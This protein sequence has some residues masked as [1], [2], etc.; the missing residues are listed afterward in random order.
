MTIAELIERLEAALAEL[1][2]SDRGQ[3]IG[4]GRF[5]IKATRDRGPTGCEGFDVPGT[6]PVGPS[7]YEGRD[8]FVW[9][10]DVSRFNSAKRDINRLFPQSAWHST[11]PPRASERENEE[12]SSIAILKPKQAQE[13]A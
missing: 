8:S 13:A 1:N 12:E 9:S 5:G 3:K 11:N 7:I 2:F 4:L 10:I 6:T